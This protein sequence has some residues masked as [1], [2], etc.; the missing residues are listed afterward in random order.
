[1]FHSYT[2]DYEMQRKDD[3]KSDQAGLKSKLLA[4]LESDIGLVKQIRLFQSVREEIW[5][6]SGM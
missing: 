1:M 3:S 2:A 4:D 6:V 5:C